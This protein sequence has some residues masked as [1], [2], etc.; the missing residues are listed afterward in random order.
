[1][2][3]WTLKELNKGQIPNPNLARKKRMISRILNRIPG[4]RNMETD[5]NGVMR[6]AS[7]EDSISWAVRVSLSSTR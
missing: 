6:T 3:V 4:M 7:I 2:D 1:M 5:W